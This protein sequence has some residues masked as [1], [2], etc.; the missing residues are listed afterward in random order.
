MKLFLASQLWYIKDLTYSHIPLQWKKIA[1]ILD[2]AKKFGWR[3]K[4]W[5]DI[6]VKVL[7]ESWCECITISLENISPESLEKLMMRVDGVFV[8]GWVTSWLAQ[9][10]KSSWF[11]ELMKEYRKTWRNF[12]YIATSAGSKFASIEFDSPEK[13]LSNWNRS[14][15]KWLWFIDSVIIPHR[16]SQRH[17]EDRKSSFD[18]MYDHDSM[19]I[20]LTDR[21][22]LLVEWK[23]VEVL[24]SS[25]A[26]EEIEAH[27]NQFAPT[28]FKE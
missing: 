27:R 18:S 19:Q 6:D 14:N 13:L 17:F 22:A 20:C 4:R 11:A 21:Q 23:K 1:I 16:W 7:E 28:V 26:K 12:W 10:A 3:E 5:V 15:N 9:V 8:S 25:K 2:A 24:T